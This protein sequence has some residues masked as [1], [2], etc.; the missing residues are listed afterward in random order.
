[1]KIE[2]ILKYILIFACI[3]ASNILSGQNEQWDIIEIN[4]KIGQTLSNPLDVEFGATFYNEDGLDMRIPGFYNGGRNWMIRFCPPKTGRWTFKTFASTPELAGKTG[5]LQVTQNT[6]NWQR[7]SVKLDPKH[8]QKFIYADGSNYF[9]MA[10][11]LDWLFAL[12][13]DND[14]AIPKTEEIISTVKENGFNQIVMNAYAFDASWGEKE[15]I[16]PKNNYAKPKVF[17]FG[18]QNENPDF[19]TLN[20]EY[21]KHLDRVIAHLNEQQMVARVMIYVW[22]KMVNWPASDSKADNMYFDYIVKR[23]QAYPNIIWDIAKEAVSY[24][25]ND[26]DYITRRIDRL[27]KLDGHN[28]LLSVHSYEYCDV[29]PDKVD[30]IS[31][32]DNQPYL[33]S[34]MRDVLEKHHSKPVVNIE[35]GAYEKT[36]HSLFDGA[37]TDPLTCLDRMYQCIFAGT[38]S[39]YYWQNAAW[40]NI[41]T[42]P[43]DLPQDKQPHFFYYQNI[44]KLFHPYHF[45]ELYPVQNMYAAPMLTNG[46]D[47]FI[48][49]LPENRTK[50]AGRLP[51]VKNKTVKVKWFD[52]LTGNHYEANDK[53]FNEDTWLAIDRPKSISGSLSIA[54]LTM[55]TE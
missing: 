50:I 28:R 19:S 17:P 54:I 52:P 4:Y 47:V 41:I 42:K 24:G 10:F 55:E 12:D 18:G 20:V 46:K 38:Y 2:S 1:M 6:K 51:T 13:A 45:N 44:Q 11:E 37:Y 22:N 29:F 7:G 16:N 15:K 14:K 31:I 35:N 5:T 49:Y 33:Y 40:Y 8:P 43:F 26:M 9:M 25:H 48:F 3:Q 27:R 39:N 23:Y 21:F 34:R 32:S 36:M 53:S 30:F